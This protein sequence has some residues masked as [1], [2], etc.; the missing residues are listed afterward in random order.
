MTLIK[1][2]WAR[3]CGNDSLAIKGNIRYFKLPGR[4]SAVI[5]AAKSRK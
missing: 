2:V 3:E 1:E 4:G 5:T